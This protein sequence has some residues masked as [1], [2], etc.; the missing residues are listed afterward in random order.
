MRAVVS[1]R[2]HRS[3]G[4]TTR[5]EDL[6]MN[7][8]RPALRTRG[9]TASHGLDSWAAGFSTV[10]RRTQSLTAAPSPVRTGINQLQ[11][12]GR[13]EFAHP[14]LTAAEE[15]PLGNYGLMDQLA[16]LLWVRVTSPLSAAIPMS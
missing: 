3:Y 1:V 16:A 2:R 4:F 15:G 9:E 5:D 6:V 10:A 12:N 11:Y 7:V 14:A 13:I 8:W